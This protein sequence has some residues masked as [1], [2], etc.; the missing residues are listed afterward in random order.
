MTVKIEQPLQ[1]EVIIKYNEIIKFKT[2]RGIIMNWNKTEDRICSLVFIKNHILNNK[3][4]Q[5]S[6]AEV[7]SFGVDKS[8]GSITM[9]FNN[10]AHH[11]EVEGIEIRTRIS[12]L[13]NNSKQSREQFEQVRNFS[14][15]EI[16]NELQKFIK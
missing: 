1:K 2:I 15:E 14:L 3:T 7:L 9:K 8:D 5:E 16:N 11:C 13:E 10:I 4:L 12:L 6:V